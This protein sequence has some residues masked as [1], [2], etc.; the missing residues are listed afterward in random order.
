MYFD[1]FLARNFSAFSPETLAEFT[2]RV[3]ALLFPR[4]SE[5]P[6]RVQHFL[7]HMVTHNWLLHYAEF[8]GISRALSGLSSRASA[9]SGMENAAKELQLNYAEYEADFREFFPQLQTF[10]TAYLNDPAL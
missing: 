7:P 10:V 9:G 8:A 4:M 5:M 6:K 3:Y 1:H 2:E